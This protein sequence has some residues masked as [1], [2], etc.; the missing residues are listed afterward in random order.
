MLKLEE[1][2]FSSDLVTACE[3]QTALDMELIQA[4]LLG[5]V[6][7]YP[8]FAQDIDRLNRD[9]ARLRAEPTR[10]GCAL[11]CAGWPTKVGHYS[12]T[13]NIRISLH[14]AST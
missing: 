11:S 12:S 9:L 7:F 13:T 1:K 14:C 2:F 3:E 8:R 5:L 4:G 6:E 10:S